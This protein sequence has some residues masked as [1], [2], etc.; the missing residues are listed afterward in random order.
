VLKEKTRRF[1]VPLGVGAHLEHWGVPAARI[2]ELAWWEAAEYAGLKLTATPARHF[3]GRAGSDTF[4]TLWASW[5]IEGQGRRI[6]FGGD[7]GYFD[8]FAEIG[9]RLGPFDLTML[10]CGAYS[11]YWPNVHMMPEQTAQANVDLGGRL[12]MPIHWGKFNLS[13]HPW[14]EPIDRLVRQAEKLDVELATPGLGGSFELGRAVPQAAWWKG[15]MQIKSARS[16]SL[17]AVS[18]TPPLRAI[19][20]QAARPFLQV[21]TGG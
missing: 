7:S 12:L 6:F 18:R 8:G 1:F 13:L 14:T 21:A 19:C 4:R 16:A 2:V 10:E 17:D 9:R 20:R 5:V 3:S 11:P 15:E